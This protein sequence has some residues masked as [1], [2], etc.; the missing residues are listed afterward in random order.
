M[1]SERLGVRLGE[2]FDDSLGG[3]FGATLGEKL[4]EM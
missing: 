4:D 3:R 1:L 2:M